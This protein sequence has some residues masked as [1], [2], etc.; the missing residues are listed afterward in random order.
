MNYWIMRCYKNQSLKIIEHLVK[1]GS[2]VGFN[3]FGRSTHSIE[4]TVG[5]VVF[6]VK[7]NRHDWY[8]DMHDQQGKR[9]MIN[10][11]KFAS[12]KFWIQLETV[13]IFAFAQNA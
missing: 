6:W 11:D 1:C 2:T 4:F 10:L 7:R 8:V 9:K 13:V 3:L 5:S 12:K